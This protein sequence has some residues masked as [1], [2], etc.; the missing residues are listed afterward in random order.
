M[1]SDMG[2]KRASGPFCIAWLRRKFTKPTVKSNR[3]RS[4]DSDKLIQIQFNGSFDLE[5]TVSLNCVFFDDANK[6]VI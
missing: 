3:K 6:V 2:G 4:Y 1:C 5:V